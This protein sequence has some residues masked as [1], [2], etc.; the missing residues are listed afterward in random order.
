MSTFKIFCLSFLINWNLVLQFFNMAGTLLLVYIGWRQLRKLNRTSKEEFIHKLKNDFFTKETRDL[1]TLIE[2]K[3]LLLVDIPNVDDKIFKIQINND[4]MEYLQDSINI[5]RKY[6]STEEVD[7]YLLQHFEDIGL[8]YKN[9]IIKIE[10]VDQQFE[11][12]LK[13]VF[14]NSQINNYIIWARKHSQDED[15]YSNFE[16]IYKE[17][18]KYENKRKK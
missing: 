14:E 13:V 15:I 2:N 3:S 6:Y 5:K 18:E 7:D 8:L 10:D 11:C 17:V 4:L 16:M 12:Y 1:F 9:G